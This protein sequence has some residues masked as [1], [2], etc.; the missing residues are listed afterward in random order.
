LL[1]FR[2]VMDRGAPTAS[3]LLLRDR[4]ALMGGVV[5]WRPLRAPQ[6]RYPGNPW[7]TSCTQLKE[8]KI[9]AALTLVAI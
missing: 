7:Y 6:G 8:I 1:A 4:K 2:H 3:G 5:S 9:M